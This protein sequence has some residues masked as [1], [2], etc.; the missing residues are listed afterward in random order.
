VSDISVLVLPDRSRQL[1]AE[2]KA[3]GPVVLS[4]SPPLRIGPVPQV[5]DTSSLIAK[6]DLDELSG[7]LALL[8]EYDTAKSKSDEID[9]L[10][11][12]AGITL[13]LVKPTRYFLE[14]RMLIDSSG[15]IKTISAES[16][17][18]TLQMPSRN[19]TLRYQ[20][21]HTLSPADVRRAAGILPE[22]RNTMATGFS[23]WVHPYTSVHRALVLFCQGYSVNL[24]D[25]RQVLWAAGLDCLFSS[26]ID[27]SKWG[28]PSH[29]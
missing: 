11:E 12:N 3:S 21:V 10:V 4:N 27:R 7:S 23:S 2:I 1:E 20:Q 24:I 13:Q 15:R 9:R 28:F 22:V 17:D 25:L 29:Q 26:K 6:P 5:T 8:C 19:P 18:V 16:R 14:Y